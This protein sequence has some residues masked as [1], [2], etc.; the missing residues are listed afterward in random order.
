MFLQFRR[1][2]LVGLGSNLINFLVY[3]LCIT[4]NLSLF[5]SSLLGYSSGLY[6]SYI[7]GRFWVF[8][9][10]F[11]YSTKQLI[12]FMIIYAV[13]GIGM[14]TVLL[15]SHY[16]FMLN[17]ELSWLFGAVFAALNNFYGQKYF[18]FIQKENK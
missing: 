14:T 12:S 16:Y 2:L 7:L 5:L 10:K 18:V 8:G 13:G 17:Y 11:N 15:I 6:F 9:V 3:Y 4:F 1:F